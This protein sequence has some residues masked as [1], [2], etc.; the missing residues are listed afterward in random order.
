MGRSVFFCDMESNEG[1]V[2]VFGLI[3]YILKCFLGDFSDFGDFFCR[4][5]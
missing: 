5:K 4:E 2:C 3:G 1:G